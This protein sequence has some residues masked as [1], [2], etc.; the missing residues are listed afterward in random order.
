M[1]AMLCLCS[2]FPVGQSKVKDVATLDSRYSVLHVEKDRGIIDL[3][4]M[5][6]AK[7]LFNRANVRKK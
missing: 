2:P 5:K 3:L 4:C 6:Y 1:V 7:A